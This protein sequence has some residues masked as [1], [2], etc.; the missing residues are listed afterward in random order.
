MQFI[1]QPD[2]LYT[3]P[4]HLVSDMHKMMYNITERVAV[5]GRDAGIISI[6][7]YILNEAI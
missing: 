5:L 7:V 2:P 4:V 3:C 6:Y 1:V